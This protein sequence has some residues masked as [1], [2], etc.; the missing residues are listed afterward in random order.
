MPAPYRVATPILPDGMPE[1]TVAFSNV[2]VG[3]AASVT[4][5]AGM[6]PIVTRSAAAGV[7]KFL[8]VIETMPP[9][10]AIATPPG[11]DGLVVKALTC[12]TCPALTVN[13]ALDVALAPALLVTVIAPVVAP[14]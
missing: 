1:G 2:A 4:T 9:A 8:P 6:P 11:P 12:G 13:L 7:R 14:A 3:L 10:A 5:V